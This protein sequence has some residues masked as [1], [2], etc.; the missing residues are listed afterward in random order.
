[1]GL[2]ASETKT[3]MDRLLRGAF[4][5]AIATSALLLVATPSYA[6]DKKDEKKDE[7]KPAGKP[8]VKL[9]DPDHGPPGT[10]VAM[11]GVNFPDKPD[12][13]TVTAGTADCLVL[14]VT[15]EEIR[16]FIPAT[17][18]PPDGPLAITVKLKSGEQLRATFKVAADK[19]AE[20]EKARR[21]QE[22][23]KYEGTSKFVDQFAENEKLLK[24]TKLE[25]TGGTNPSCVVE[26]ESSLP[27]EFFV[28]VTFGFAGPP[29]EK[30]I[31][32]RKIMIRGNQWKVVFG[33]YLGKVL[34][35]GRYYVSVAFEMAKQSPIDLKR[36]GWPDKLS[37]AERE[38]RAYIWKKEIR[39]VGTADDQAKQDAEIRAHYVD[40]CKKTTDAFEQL[41]RNYAAAGKAYF[42]KPS[43]SGYDED[44]WATWVKERGLGQTDAD[45]K[46]LKDDNRFLRGARFNPDEWLKYVEGDLFKNLVEI[47]KRHIQAKERY[48]GNR[49]DRL[50]VEGDYLISIVVKL[51]QRYSSEIYE[52]EK[53][54]LPDSLRM[55]K[56]LIGVGE[57]VAVSR[58][59][60]EGHRKLLMD[61]IGVTSLD[62]KGDKKD[63]KK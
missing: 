28:A 62:G 45:M 8:Q 43:G 54:A 53:I 17:P 14:S 2:R 15:P 52:R 59:H 16:F 26:G 37:E 19:S 47:S 6:Q 35:A 36:A 23:S 5:A 44:G 38:A 48:V 12:G 30:Q 25:I 11:R 27:R 32:A 4:A 34:L 3:V 29:E 63:D 50:H 41:E 22:R 51:T 40:L 21:E 49:D 9:L 20:A 18:K 39:D 57:S 56:D 46:K 31:E 61:R 1:M 10:N 33:P 55:P 60:F 42:R 58:A 24:I 7:A 13:V